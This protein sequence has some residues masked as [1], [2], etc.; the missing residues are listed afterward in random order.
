MDLATDGEEGFYKAENSDY[1]AVLLDVMLPKLDG[2]EVLKRLRKIKK[3]PLLMLTVRALLV[4]ALWHGVVMLQAA[5]PPLPVLGPNQ[6]SIDVWQVE[7][8]LPDN[9]VTSIAQTPDGYLWLGTFRGP[10]RFDGLRFET[11]GP[12]T[13]GLGS[14]RVTQLFR[15]AAGGLWLAMEYGQLAR[16]AGGRFTTFSTGEGWP[17]QR[18]ESFAQALDGPVVCNTMQAAFQFVNGRFSLL[19]SNSLLQKD[20]SIRVARDGGGQLWIVQDGILGMMRDGA[21]SPLAGELETR[22]VREIKPSRAGGLWV[23]GNGSIREL[24]NGQWVRDLGTHPGVTQDAPGLLEDSA[25]RLWC[26]TWRNGLFC[27]LPDGSL[28]HFSKENGLP[29]NALRTICEDREGNLW[30]GFNGGGLARLKPRVFQTYPRLGSLTNIVFGIAE[31]VSGG[32]WLG[33]LEGGLWR[34]DKGRFSTMN[35]TELPWPWTAWS[36]LVDRAGGLWVAATANEKGGLIHLQEGRTTYYTTNSGLVHYDVLCLFEARDGSIWAGTEFGLSRLHNGKFSNYTRREGLAADTVRAITEDAA[37][38]LWVGTTG[39]GLHRR[40]AGRFEVFRRAD[41]LAG[42][43][44]Q[45]LL[46]DADG[47]LWVG[48][49]DGLS[50]FRGGQWKTFSRKHGLPGNDINTILDDG[51]GFLWLGTTHG[52]ARVARPELEA[53][54]SGAK[55]DLDCTTYLKA[56]GLESIQCTSGGAPGLK[57]RDGRLWFATVGGLSVVDPQKISTNH[58]APQLV[59][60]EVL[61]DGTNHWSADAVATIPPGRHQIEVRFTGL[62]FT[63]PERV[64][65]KH[66]LEGFDKE[67]QEAGP[68]R[69]AYYNGLPP[70]EYRFQVIAANND[71]VWNTTGA[72]LALVVQ[73]AFW[74]T[75]WFRA[76]AVLLLAGAGFAFYRRRVGALELRRAQQ[77]AFTRQLLESQEAERR[78]I[79]SELHDSLGQDLLLVKNLAMLGQQT[80]ASTPNHFAEISAATTRA[81]DEVHA[82]SYALR[83]PELDRLGLAKA[84]GAMVRRAGDASGIP[85]QR[86]LELDGPLPPGA[87]IQ[88]FRIAQEAVNNLVKHARAKSARAELWRDEAGVHL[89][90][91]DDGCGF[92]V[93]E[94]TGLSGLGLAGIDERVQLLG[95]RYEIISRPGGGTTLTV[96]VPL[97]A[98]GSTHGQQS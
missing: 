28:E 21:W 58:I 25:G 82:I 30:L 51:L 94:R 44:V 42:D 65:F 70:G 31:D 33:T 79:A 29:E 47:T 60:E 66:R 80:H 78:R 46:A 41:G 97:R 24:R 9:T 92:A 73:P 77:E 96:L 98:V 13:P 22:N 88:L 27:F 84:L 71:G 89:V 43:S 72:V 10:V 74:Q 61:V 4:A 85:F 54:A 95:G 8:G 35:L 57:T 83:P 93:A 32:L 56:D 18:A 45:S 81:L 23:C 90:I 3:T 19:S 36:T 91:A 14:E 6:F 7:Q 48:T 26:T 76:A 64:R 75:L 62:S 39:G 59:I 38:D 5:P 12:S 2:W 15:D 50:R 68:R 67:W 1:D 52:M 86:H 63:A 20:V 55:N 49:S 69:T 16:Y 87:D 53:V 34:M 11:F 37:G 17:G 40:R